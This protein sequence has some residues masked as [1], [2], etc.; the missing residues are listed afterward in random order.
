MINATIEN[1]GLRE[2]VANLHSFQNRTNLIELPFFFR[3]ELS[4]KTV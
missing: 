2:S 1:Q 4:A 3:I